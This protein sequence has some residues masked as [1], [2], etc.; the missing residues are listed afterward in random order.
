MIRGTLSNGLTYYV[1]PN[2]EPQERA[3]LSLVVKAGSV[4]EEEDQRGLA[5]FVE[6]MAFNGTE[7][8]AKQEI[9]DYLESIGSAF[10]PDLNAQTGYDSTIYWL[11]IPTE[12]PEVIETAFQILS[13]W[14]YALTFD[15]TEV[16]QERG[17]I[18]EEWRGRQGFGSRLRDELFP[19]LF[20]ASRYADRHPIGQLEIVE[21]APV[22]RLRAFYESWYTPDRI[23]VV[24]V[25]DF[26]AE[27][28][29]SSIARHFAPPPEG[30]AS[31]NGAA[32]EPP[33]E[34]PHFDIPAH[35]APRIKVFSDPEA[36][37]TQMIL[38][39]KV[40]PESGQDLAA[41]R[42][43]AVER[44]AFMMVNSRLSERRQVADPP[45]LWAGGRRGPLVE[46]QDIVDF[47]AWV[48]Q[49]GVERG[50]QALLEELQRASRH[51]F[52]DTELAREKVNLL[53]S[54]ESMYKQRDQM[55]SSGLSQ[56]Y[57]GHFL[58]GAPVQGI[59]AEWELYQEV[60]P[61]IT[62]E[63]T[64]DVA[65]SWVQT[66]NTV[67]LVMMP[68][69]LDDGTDTQLAAD[70]GRQLETADSLA[71]EPYTD[72]FADVP[73]M[74]SKPEPGTI[75]A[76]EHIESIDAEKWTLSNGI[77]VVAKQ[78]DFR[79]NEVAFTAFSPGGHSLVD[80]ADHVSALYAARLATGSGVGLHDSVTV[81]KLLAGKEV[82][83]SPYI[84]ELFEGFSGNA[85]PEDL[86]VMFQLI[87]LYATTPRFDQAYFSR[88]ETSLRSIAETR[89]DQPDA[90]LFDTVNAALS[91]HHFRDRPLTPELLDELSIERA[92]AVYADRFADLGDATFIF[93]GAFDR[94][95]LKSFT[96]TY[97]AS[98]PTDGRSEQWRD[99]GIDPPSELQE[100]FV[101]SG[102]EP[103]SSSVLVFA[104]EMEY[105]EEESIA[106]TAAT[107]MLE[108]RL[109][110][111]LREDL[112]GTYSIGVN[113][114][115]SRMPD[116]EY[117]VYVLYG[118]DPSRADELFQAVKDELDWLRTGGE[119][120]YLERVKE[121]LR[122]PRQEQ[123]RSNGFWISRIQS[124]LQ[125]GEP[126]ADISRFDERL[127]ALTLE[128]IAGAAQ[129]FL[130][131]DQYVRV[132]LLP[133]SE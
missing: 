130:P 33:T 99:V 29:E 36:P 70:I 127:E 93:V 67:L 133:E 121:L 109:R 30:E 12:E 46:P 17:V 108:I 75:T 41:F 44:L 48:E 28:I 42:R 16:E 83:V 57:I 82:S 37:G 3:Q 60:L 111:R 87:N 10:G 72:N 86:E 5:H 105:T 77:T 73:L 45:Y 38:A 101:R 51:G 66:D 32:I 131:D 90:V 40:T 25:G 80:D 124:A 2:K 18:V 123:L 128:R 13:D 78:T 103:R 35:S 15:A 61:Q 76:E 14:A 62:P 63:E 56:T 21:N 8:F 59:E 88:F 23:A 116:S 7:R 91:Q 94:E 100:Y 22:E 104:G 52:T 9:I 114:S 50:L 117:R 6:H 102:I 129:K 34:R 11:E 71:V 4:L 65:D 96:A 69:E 132:V 49:D 119:Q 55:P 113:A 81:D 107:D 112:G 39:R 64:D 74:A 19:L 92:K 115:S 24:A 97:L 106:L 79:D 58:D 1:R 27:S 84:G 118:S 120:E 54:V 98:L 126:F 47:S 110:E 85:S 68:G 95:E 26:D 122:S 125:H 31:Q 20:G 43:G 53:S 89:T